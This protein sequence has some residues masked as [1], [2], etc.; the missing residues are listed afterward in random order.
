MS[1]ALVHPVDIEYVT[2]WLVVFTLHRDGNNSNNA[3]NNNYRISN[4]STKSSEIN[5]IDISSEVKYK[6]YRLDISSE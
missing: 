5:F 3:I 6:Q 4:N 2:L 1:T